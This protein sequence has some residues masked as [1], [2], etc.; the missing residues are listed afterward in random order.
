MTDTEAPANRPGFVVVDSGPIIRGARLDHYVTEL[1]CKLVTI[2]EVISEL[3][4]AKARQYLQSL[5]FEVALRQPSDAS[6]AAV[7]AFARK[8]GDYATLSRVDLRVLALTHMLHVQVHGSEQLKA[9][10]VRAGAPKVET[11]AKTPK[12]N[13]ALPGWGPSDGSTKE[14]GDEEGWITSKNIDQFTSKDQVPE[15]FGKGDGPRVAC[16]TTDFTMQNVMLQ[17]GMKVLS[18]DGL[19]IKKTK[20]WR[21][22]CHACFKIT[23]D[24]ER[25]F[26]GHCGNHT[27]QRVSCTVNDDGTVEVQLPPRQPSIRGTRYSIPNPKGGKKNSDVILREDEL[28]SKQ[29]GHARRGPKKET[30]LFDPD[31]QFFGT[32]HVRKGDAQY[33]SGRRNPNQNRRR[34]K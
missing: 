31:H 21:N 4:D 16:T 1:G 32:Q 19:L 28:I 17:M 18:V 12:K 22:R 10:P 25:E 30:D 11:A 24:M 13:D 34:K 14:M 2:P 15:E 20:Q 23:D 26:C 27:M 6:I 8:S 7:V 33:G 9:E 3:R 5:P 29:R